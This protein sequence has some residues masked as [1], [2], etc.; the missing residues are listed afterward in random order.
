MLVALAVVGSALVFNGAS[1][2]SPAPDPAAKIKPELAQQLENKGEATFWVRFDQA[3]LS[4]ASAIKDWDERGQAVYDALTAAAESGQEGTRQLLDSEDVTYQ[5]FWATNAIRVEGGSESLALK[6]AESPEVAALY[7][8]FDYRLE[9]PT[10]GTNQHEVDAV[11]WGIANINADDVWGD[12]GVQGEGL[13]IANIDTGVQFDHPAL[14]SQYRG[15]NGDGTFNHN[16]NWFN[17]AGTCA[18]APC[19]TNGHGTHTMGTMVG[20]DGAANQVGVAPGATWIAA[21]GCCPSDAAL[22]SS[23]E[24]MLAPTDLAGDN[25]DVTKRPNIINNSWGSQVPSNDPFMEDVQEAW[26]ASGIFGSWSNGNSGPACST[27]G[28]P[29]SR[30]IN[31][32]VGAYDINN[33]IASFSGRGAGQAGEIKPN[34]SAPGVNVRSSVPGNG[35]ASFNGTSMASPHLA[36]TIALL[37][38]AAPSMLGDIDATRALL[39]G[40]ALDSNST[41]CGGT[42]DDNNVYGEGRLD[43]LALLNAA[44]VG[45]TGTVA[46]TVTDAETGD[47]LAGATVELTGEFSRTVTTDDAGAYSVRVAVGAYTATASKFGYLT[48]SADV[49]VTTDQTTTQDFALSAAPSVTLSG[50]V[51]DGGEHGWPLYASVDVSGPAEDVYTDPA[52]GE[53]A[54]TVPSGASYDVTFTSQY[55]GYEPVTQEVVLGDADTTQDAALPVDSSTCTAAGYRFNTAGVTEDFNS[56]TQP[57]GWSVVDHIGTGQVWT[58]NNPGGRTNLTGGS[59]GFAVM[60]SDEWGS[61]GR[62]DTSL[63][64]PVIDMSSLSAPVVG[65]KQDYNNLGD[66]ADVDVSVDGGATWQTVLHQTTDVRGPREDVLQLPTAAGQSQVQIRF[67]QYDADFDWWWEVDDVFVGNRTCDPIPGGLVVGNV[68]AQSTG[69]AINGAKVTSLDQPEETATTAPTPDD[70][71]LGDGFYW[72]FSTLTG[73]HPFEAS[74]NQY[75]VATETVDV[76]EDSATDADFVLGSGH[77]TV[78]PDAVSATAEL[79]KA[80]VTRSFEVANDGSAPAT[81]EFSERKGGFTLL[82]ADGSRTNTAGTADQRGAPLQTVNAP[83]SFAATSGKGAQNAEPDASGPSE[84]PWTDIADY[85]ATVMDNRVV[86]LDGVAYSIAGGNGSASTAA[87]RAYDPATLSWSSKAPPSGC[88]QRGRSGCRS[89]ARSW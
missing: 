15:N 73:T 8:T 72:M 44:P 43:A 5:S 85:P 10:K 52:T 75:Q 3:D 76:A 57:A 89:T 49:T 69:D 28:S 74:A 19:D 68:T 20:D 87:V 30:I 84:A 62:Q 12:F 24:W 77:L 79:G 34:I 78:T 58:F 1:A 27:S 45:E 42:A 59:G 32:S 86:Y 88:P 14:A 18:A 13:V 29:G 38:S 35:Y 21:N 36:G 47:P 54:V 67:H 17:A 2:A 48:G 55:P 7:P 64:T 70:A 83:V 6:V 4:A 63:V 11:E 23:G 60:D 51:T 40:T 16:Y 66:F 65:F 41:T 9:E 82:S 71:A 81:V 37:W 46:G 53:Y 50:T 31:Y 33:T 39:D 56:G 80:P 61:G 25:A 26:A 22:I